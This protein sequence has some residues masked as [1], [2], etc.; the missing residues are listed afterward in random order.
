MAY[1]SLEHVVKRYKMGEVTITAVD[2]ITFDNNHSWQINAL[3]IIADKHVDVYTATGV[4]VASG[5]GTF[6]LPGA[7]LY[8]VV[9][10]GSAYKIIAK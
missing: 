3:H 2:D 9:E 1:I 10:N 8:I 6:N 7:G 4:L 5:R